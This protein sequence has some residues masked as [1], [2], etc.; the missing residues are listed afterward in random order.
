M[1]A[2]PDRVAGPARRP[3]GPVR[4]RYRP[5]WRRRR[6]RGPERAFVERSQIADRA[7]L[8]VSSHPPKKTPAVD[9]ALASA[10]LFRSARGC[11]RVS[12]H[13]GAEAW[14]AK[15]ALP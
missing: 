9:P 2:P 14:Q 12:E 6:W 15:M 11:E 7:A 8:R 10:R 5:R 4:G 13:L 1:V 3:A